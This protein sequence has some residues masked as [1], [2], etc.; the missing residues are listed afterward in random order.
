M[1]Q[2][3]YCSMHKCSMASDAEG[4]PYGVHSSE[5]CPAQ[6]GSK[7]LTCICLITLQ[8][9]VRQQVCG[10]IVNALRQVVGLGAIDSPPL[11]L[12]AI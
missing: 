1:V 11:H 4:S 12:Q 10:F 2:S 3:E 8:G 6:T 7:V 5:M 9:T